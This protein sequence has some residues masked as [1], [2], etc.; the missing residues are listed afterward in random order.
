[1]NDPL[2][3]VFDRMVPLVEDNRDWWRA[4]VRRW[5]SDPP[6]YFDD[7]GF[8]DGVIPVPFPQ[9]A[10]TTDEQMALLAAIYDSLAAGIE[11]I[12][13]W[14][15]LPLMPL[16]GDDRAVLDEHRLALRYGILLSDRVP[17]LRNH[18][19]THHT[20]VELFVDEA[21]RNCPPTVTGQTAEA[22]SDTSTPTKPKRSTERGEGR[23]KLIAALTKHHRYADGGCLNLEPI[24]NNELARLAGV[25]QA[26]ASAFFK[27]QFGG[28]AKYWAICADAAQLT[29]ALK[30]LNGEFAP[31]HLYGGKP[32][33]EGE[34]DEE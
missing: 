31:H 6:V 33:G 26:T 7:D 13:P 2:A 25:D 1:M 17:E 29:A 22:A 16:L 15:D 3:A 23:V 9:A 4:A 30:L 12:D 11:R 10:L 21:K 27:Q 5:A 18:W 20:K 32:A 19:A 14:R 24:G 8:E 28:H 34:W